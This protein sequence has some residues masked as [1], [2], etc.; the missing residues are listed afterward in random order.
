MRVWVFLKLRR[1]AVVVVWNE[2]YSFRGETVTVCVC[3]EEGEHRPIGGRTARQEVF[4]QQEDR[5]SV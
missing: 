4:Y 1:G 3:V 5:A 2:T